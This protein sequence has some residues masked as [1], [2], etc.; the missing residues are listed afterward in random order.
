[1][2][3]A[4]ALA[5]LTSSQV[6]TILLH[7]LAH[8]RR[9]DYLVNLVQTIA[10]TLL[11][12][13]PAVWWLSSRIRAERE[14]CCDDTVVRL[15]GDALEYATALAEL[16]ASRG[17]MRRLAMA[18]SAGSLL[19]RIGR[20]LRVPRQESFRSPGWIVTLGLTLFFTAA[21]GSLQWL[22]STVA[23]PTAN[24]AQPRSTQS[25]SVQPALPIPG[26]GD[27][28]NLRLDDRQYRLRWSEGLRYLEARGYGD[29]VFSADLTD[30][31]ALAEGGYLVFREWTGLVPRSIEIRSAGRQLTRKY[32]VAGFERKWSRE[33]QQWLTDRL[34][35][36]VRRS[37]LG[38]AS[39]TRQIFAS[40]GVNGVFDE[41]GRLEGDYARRLYFREL[42]RLD[43][44]LDRQATIRAVSMAGQLIDSDYYLAETLSE[45]APTAAADPTVAQAYV[46]AADTLNS[47]YE[48]RRT[49]VALLRAGRGSTPFVTE[50]A[51]QSAASMR[52]DYERAETLRSA[53]E[54]GRL[55]GEGAALYHAIEGMRSDYEK[56]RVLSVV[57]ADETARQVV[58][59]G[60]A[61]IDSDYECA[62]LLLSYL[63]RHRVD[64]TTSRAFFAAV[65]TIQSNYERKRVL[66]GLV[67]VSPIES[68]IVKP[69]LDAVATMTSDYERAEILLRLVHRQPLDSASRAA[70]IDVVNGMSSDHEQG[71]VLVALVRAERG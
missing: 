61:T 60:A 23:E 25:G 19:D 56:R 54:A 65:N 46:D 29:V 32:Y 33:A 10:E 4:A 52:S 53:A 12:Y 71:R 47:D 28:I 31:Q 45:L 66:V 2:L 42:M 35:S 51:L 44:P 64:A 22:P 67:A 21:A 68:A 43:P 5:G 34:P 7:E 58:L 9:H 38:A 57:I 49:L 37:G 62:T 16:E 26:D 36:L 3:P 59:A 48:H 17:A 6:E 20:V 8:I 40:R 1:M 41:I 69:V 11:F 70:V 39:R 55:G 13:H 27:T 24:A 15:S 50:L 30:V 18:A 14:Y 63:E